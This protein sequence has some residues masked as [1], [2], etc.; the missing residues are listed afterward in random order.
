MLISL[1]QFNIQRPEK[2]TYEFPLSNSVDL[3][4]RIKSKGLKSF[5]A[6]TDEVLV[7]NSIELKYEDLTE[8]KFADW[9][10][11]Y[12]E[13]MEENH[14]DVL[15]KL[16]W[17]EDKKDFRLKGIFLYQNKKLVGSGI[18]RLAK[19]IADFE[20]KAS[21]K[22][23][24]SSKPSSSIGSIIEFLFLRLATKEGYKIASSRSRNA[25]GFFNTLEYL[26]YKLRFG[27]KPIPS[28]GVPVVDDVPVNETGRV[29]FYGLQDG[30]FCLFSLQ[31]ESEKGKDWFDKSR[32]TSLETPLREIYY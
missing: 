5:L 26:D 11:Y 18:V 15:A 21:D 17:Y 28:P 8:Q 25:F 27:Y 9:L 30:K 2:V 24:V 32:F 20:F 4:N 29:L 16:E 14:H 1:T 19:D 6:T 13:K 7:K 22:I 31:P 3:I 12:K 10:P 23:N